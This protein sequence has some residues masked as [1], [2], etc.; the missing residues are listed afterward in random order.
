MITLNRNDFR[1]KYYRNGFL[2]GTGHINGK[3]VFLG[4]SSICITEMDVLLF[5]AA[6]LVHDLQLLDEVSDLV[7]P[8][9]FQAQ[10]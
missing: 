2:Q 3:S 4:L 6:S 7:M 5:T 9:F 8:Y 1:L 10:H